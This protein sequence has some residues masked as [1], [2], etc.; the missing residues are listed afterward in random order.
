[1]KEEIKK[2]DE[3]QLK[4]LKIV[5]DNLN[6]R[7]EK[8]LT[9]HQE[10]HKANMKANSQLIEQILKLR[11]D[12]KR[13]RDLFKQKGGEKMLNQILVNEAKR[14]KLL[15]TM[16]GETSKSYNFE[17]ESP[18]VQ[19]EIAKKRQYISELRS[20]LLDLQTT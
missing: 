14:E 18:E 10:D 3:A 1:M 6:S 4:F 8:E 19:K 13:S 2:E 20:R 9:L 12:V 17:N 15:E 16:T 5:G 7:I 11:G